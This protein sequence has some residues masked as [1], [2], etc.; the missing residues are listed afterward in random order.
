MTVKK[1]I[2]VPGFRKVI[3]I[4]AL[5]FFSFLSGA[6]EYE[7]EATIGFDTTE[8]AEVP[9]G[10]DTDGVGASAAE[11]EYFYKKWDTLVLTQRNLPGGVVKKMKEDEDFWYA[12]TDIN[13]KKSKEQLAYERENG[14]KGQKGKNE[15]ALQEQQRKNN[16]YT[17]V[18]QRS[19]FQTL[20]WIFIIG[21]FVVVL[22]MYLSSS[23][24]GLFRKRNVLTA[25]EDDLIT[26]DIF[27]INYQK[28][29]DKAAA[30]GN[31]RLAIRLMFLRLLKNLAEKN[32]ILYKQ[33]KTN[34]D[35]LLE[36]HATN[37]YNHFFR[38]TRNYE[39]SWYG[40]FSVSEDAYK[41]IR[42][43]FDGFDKVLK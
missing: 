12:N 21:G 28:E 19:W 11:K 18:G 5:L 2:P 22:A 41:V 37:Y 13:K 4:F 16:S 10:E 29:I 34:L 26:G 6:Q 17:P 39:Y 15:Q 30:Q 3:L 1:N 7:K 38:I 35:Y 9:A 25:D 24:V 32:I 20:L 31:Y 23:N 27:A 36:L 40:Q 42:S 8:V 33:D 14:Q 43:D